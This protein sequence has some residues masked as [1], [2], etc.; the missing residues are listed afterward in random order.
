MKDFSSLRTNE[1]LW[2]DLSSCTQNHLLSALHSPA[3]AFPKLP[4]TIQVKSSRL[5]I[6]TA[7]FY[8]HKHHMR[9]GDNPIL[10]FAAY[11][12][13][14]ACCQV[15][16]SFSAFAQSDHNLRP[17]I[18]IHAMP[19]W[20]WILSPWVTRNFG[21]SQKHGNTKWNPAKK[22]QWAHSFC[23]CGRL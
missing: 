19:V 15:G 3:P 17:N 11:L 21:E 4:N 8:L 1:R 13:L 18:Q 5:A 20:T 14:S 22:L 16:Q 2:N 7:V 9:Q 12:L 23:I 6:S 10:P